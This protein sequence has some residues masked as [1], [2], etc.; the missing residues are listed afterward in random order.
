M[1]CSVIIPVY[2][3]ADLIKFTLNSLDAGFHSG[4]DLEI[5]VVDD[6]STDNVIEIVRNEYP[7]VIVAK[8]RGKGAP[9]AR[10]TGLAI[11]KSEYILFLDS[12][13][14]IA[15]HFFKRKIELMDKDMTINACYGE[16][17]FFE[18]DMEFDDSYVVFKHKYPYIDKV[19]NVKDHL[20]NYLGGNFLPPNSIVWRRDLLEKINGYD[21]KLIVNQDVDLVIRAL[22]NNIKLVAVKDGTRALIR[23]HTLDNRVGT[24][25]NSIPKLKSIIELRK[26]IFEHHIKGNSEETAYRK[27]LSIYLFNFWRSTRHF[28]KVLASDFLNLSKE[29]FW[30]IKVKGNLFL[31]SLASILGPVKAIELKYFLLKRD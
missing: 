10:N 23:T 20:I 8:N 22:F 15:E 12:D 24:A 21:E 5:I 2:N 25:N 17:D 1:Q 4:V 11:S 30:P 28:D 3:R 27:A 6:G 13:D 7:H 16:Y 31:R 18:C 14:L 19:D 9:A 29:V 26:Q